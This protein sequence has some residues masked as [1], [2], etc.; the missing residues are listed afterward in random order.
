MAELGI[1]STLAGAANRL[2]S[3]TIPAAVYWA[4]VPGIDPDLVGQERGQA[5]TA[6]R[7]QATV[8]APF[9]DACHISG[10][11]RQEVQH[12]RD[13]CPVEVAVGLHPAILG[14]H[15]VVDHR[16]EFPTSNLF[17]VVDSVPRGAVDLRTAPQGVRVLH[18]VGHVVTVTVHNGRTRQEPAQVDRRSCLTRVRSKRL[19]IGREHPVGPE[20][21]LHGHGGCDISKVQQ[22]P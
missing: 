2:S 12:V 11:D 18:D 4:N 1:E 9:T 14:D 17:G 20:Q 7:I 10:R 19:Q 8:G 15:R 6:V 16:V 5:V 21:R 22:P 13:R 3:D